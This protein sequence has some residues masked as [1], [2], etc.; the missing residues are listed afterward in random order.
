MNKLRVERTKDG[1]AK[2]TIPQGYMGQCHCGKDAKHKEWSVF[3]PPI[4]ASSIGGIDFPEVRGIW[5]YVCDDHK[6][7]VQ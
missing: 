1:G 7:V 5:H 3:D 6:A 4:P 2:I